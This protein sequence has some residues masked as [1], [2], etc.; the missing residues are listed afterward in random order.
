M[1]IYTWFK[2]AANLN[3]DSFGS[4][5]LWV[6]KSTYG[7]FI[8][9]RCMIQERISIVKTFYEIN[10]SLVNTKQCLNISVFEVISGLLQEITQSFD[11]L[12]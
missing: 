8:M 9:R 4:C 2:F 3:V 5:N 6:M 10:S 12:S 11:K 7:K 1:S